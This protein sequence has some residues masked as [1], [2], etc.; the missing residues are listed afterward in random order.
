MKPTPAI[1]FV[2]MGNICRSPTAEGVMRQRVLEV[3][4]P[5]YGGVQGF[6]QVLDYIEDAADGLIR[7]LRANPPDKT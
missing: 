4:A 3:P 6:D 2:C 7:D 5:Y 1:L